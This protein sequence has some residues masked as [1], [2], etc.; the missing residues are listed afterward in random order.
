[1][2]RSRHRADQGHWEILAG[3]KKVTCPLDAHHYGL[4]FDILAPH[5][6]TGA[7]M[8][9]EVKPHAKAKLTPREMA[10]AALFPDY[11]R[12]VNSLDDA[13]RAVGAIPPPT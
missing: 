2:F 5:V 12:R 8:M 10:M 13:L 7:P 9:L 11:W 3:L 6:K 1:M 4:G